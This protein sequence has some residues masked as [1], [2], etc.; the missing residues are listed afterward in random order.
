ML[1]SLPPVLR[2]LVLL[3]IAA[4]L[5]AVA[6]WVGTDLGGVIAQYAPALAP[7]AGLIVTVV[8]A[9]LTPLTRQYGVGSTTP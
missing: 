4:V 1:D 2:H 5:T 9:V 8:L 7:V 6:Q 3:L